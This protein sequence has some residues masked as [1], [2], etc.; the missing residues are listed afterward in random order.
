MR[1][2]AEAA[3]AADEA[4]EVKQSTLL[5]GRT[6][7]TLNRDWTSAQLPPGS[8]GSRGR[9]RALCSRR[10]FDQGEMRGLESKWMLRT[11]ELDTLVSC[12]VGVIIML[13]CRDSLG[14]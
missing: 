3:E 4:Y 14:R 1:E 12:C 8:A 10:G 7:L 2:A 6:A 5:G 11:A 9:F 13:Q